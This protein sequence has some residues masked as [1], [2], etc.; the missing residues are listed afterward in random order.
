MTA[1][2]V[3]VHPRP[4]SAP[5]AALAPLYGLFD[6][7]VDGVNVT[8]RIGETQALALLAELGHAVA[9]LA[10]GRRS[11]ATVQLHAEDQAWELG[12]EATGTEVWLTVFRAGATPEVAVHERATSLTE[13]VVA[14]RA[15]LGDAPR[16][17]ELEPLDL[18]LDSAARA[19]AQVGTPSPRLPTPRVAERVQGSG[20]RTLTIATTLELRRAP[21]S[22]DEAAVER[23][24]LHS[25]LA[26]GPVEVTVR[27]R[28]ASLGAVHAFLFAEQLA[29]LAA[30][31]LDAWQ[32]GRPLFRR[33]DLGGPRLALRRGP[34]EAPIALS[35][36]SAEQ[37]S[38]DERTTFP[39][40]EPLHFVSAALELG[41]R[42]IEAFVG[43]DG[44]QRR[45]L[46]LS[47][48]ADALAALGER[49][50]GLT[51][52]T[53]L[54]NPT[55]ESYRAFA[56]PRRSAGSGAEGTWSH[57]GKMRFSPRWVATVPGIDLAATFVCGDRLIVGAQREMAAIDRA[58]GM[59]MWRV[60]TTRAA[61]VPT[62]LGV[63][64]LHPEG[65]VVVHGVED[66]EARFS[67]NLAPRAAGGASGAVVYAPGLPRLLVVAEGDRR[68]T[69]LDLATGDVRWRYT[70]RRAAGYRV[71]RAGRLLLVAGGD[72]AL[73]AL[74]AVTGEVVWRACDRLP[75]T[76]EV[77]VDHDAV[78][79]LGGLPQSSARLHRLD[80]YEGTVR[81]SVE[82]DERAAGGVAP[83]VT[84][85]AV[86]VVTR[87][88]R[89]LGA[90]AFQRETG[91]VLWT[92]APGMVGATTAWLTIDETLIA[93]S[94]SGVL[95]CLDATTGMVRY[96]HVFSRQVDADQPR[97]LEPVLQNGAL[98]VPQQQVHVL[99]P[100]TGEE[101]G[102]VPSD[103]IPDLLRVDERSEVYVAEE[104]GH[105]AVFGAAPRL[106]L[107]R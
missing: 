19:L 51:E 68:V 45:N 11:R 72:T 18:A 92:Q 62:P 54:E 61:S 53:S 25:L 17:G 103:L 89:G 5:S 100:Q 70:A 78:F 15:A 59:V 74:D 3:V 87:D 41:Q 28:T 102:S 14:V 77:T 40:I 36:S 82:V 20:G 98:F 106:S 31:L 7:V 65:R 80:P 79:A 33:L 56:L 73:V 32:G 39:E 9:Q 23:S 104:S 8:A 63:A 4:E 91:E 105:L 101:L 6:V 38:R 81:W 49:M 16:S 71:R 57:G 69:A 13:L 88:R 35:V 29:T 44:A 26:R 22:S 50:I 46:R 97:R 47:A 93:N 42:L 27:G 76:G 43:N 83:L 86:V 96:S 10:S 85:S 67:V 107:V 21:S 1:I 84:P 30:E 2:H 99:R 52:D 12:L 48:L 55:P 66:G 60:A 34:G 95:T 90:R 64:R 75:F 94:A 24:D 37:R 58:S